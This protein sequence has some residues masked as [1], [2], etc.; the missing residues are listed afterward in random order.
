MQVYLMIVEAE[1][2]TAPFSSRTLYFSQ[3][4]SDLDHE[5][6]I[7]VAVMCLTMSCG[8]VSAVESYLT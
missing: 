5:S 2:I 3:Y 1:V 7:E 6:K 4:F 8:Q